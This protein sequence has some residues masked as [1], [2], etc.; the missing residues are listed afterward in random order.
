MLKTKRVYLPNPNLNNSYVTC[1]NQLQPRMVFENSDLEELYKSNESEI[2]K[3]V[4]KEIEEYVNTY[5]LCNDEDDMF[6]RL[7]VLTGEWYLSEVYFENE[8]YLSVLVAFLG[9]DLGYKDDYLGLDLVFSY[10][11]KNKKFMIDGINSS[12]I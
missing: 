6:P 7:S 10:D 1:E 12:C 4:E 3:I 9:T 8:N 11:D 5:D 2:F